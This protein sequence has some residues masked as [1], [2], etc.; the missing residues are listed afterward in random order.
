MGLLVLLYLVLLNNYFGFEEAG[1]ENRTNGFAEAWILGCQITVLAAMFEY[2]I[3]LFNMRHYS[4]N[5]KNN[6]FLY[7][8]ARIKESEKDELDEDE[9][10]AKNEE[11]YRAMDA[12]ALVF[13]PLL[14]F[15]FCMC[16]L[17]A[18]AITA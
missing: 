17:L 11:N 2:A 18:I 8:N 7:I 5:G 13:V 9:M 12:R 6:R 4:K 16:Y 1:P 15:I 14:F 3:I 10:K